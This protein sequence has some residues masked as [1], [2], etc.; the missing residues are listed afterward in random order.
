MSKESI[1]ETAKRWVQQK[2]RTEQLERELEG[3]TNELMRA[4]E[5]LCATTTTLQECV[6]ANIQH[7]IIEVD[8]DVD[9]AILVRYREGI[10]EM[11]IEREP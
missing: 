6:G 11:K 2:R 3:F 1:V 7:R 4:R 5:R 9:L 8:R 10:T